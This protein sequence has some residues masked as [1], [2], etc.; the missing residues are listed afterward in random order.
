MRIAVQ[1]RFFLEEQSA[2]LEVGDDFRVG[3]LHKLAG[4][5]R[6]FRA[7]L[8]RFVD[9]VKRGKVV[10]HP[11]L[12]IVLAVRGGDVHNASTVFRGDKVSTNYVERLF[13]N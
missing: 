11:H 1:V 5:I 3:V 12:V 10:L 13:I 2:F 6:N 7:K 9:R 8:A 4:K